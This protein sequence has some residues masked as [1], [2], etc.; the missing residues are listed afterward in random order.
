MNKLY[1]LLLVM[2]P[3]AVMAQE[4][5]VDRNVTVER[6]Y[7]PVIE[8]AG[9]ISSL[10]EI[11]EPV[12]SRQR[13]DYSDIFKPLPLSRYLQSLPM[14]QYEEEKRRRQEAFVRIGLGNHWNTLGEITLPI[15]KKEKDRLDVNFRHLG[16]FGNRK[17]SQ[18]DG[19][20]DYNHLFKTTELVASAGGTHRFFNYFGANFSA[21]GDRL[22]ADS[23]TG[24]IADD[25]HWAYQLQLG[26]RSLPDRDRFRHAG[27][28]S[29]DVLNSPSGWQENVV[30]VR[31][32][33]ST[34]YKR[35][36]YGVDFDL[37]NLTYK[38]PPVLTAAFPDY[39]VLELNPYYLLES[40]NAS[41][42]LGAIA[43][44][45][46]VTGRAFNPA[47]DIQAEW[48]VFPKFLAV[49]GG[50][51]GGFTTV[52]NKRLLE[53][54]PWVKPSLRVKDTYTPLKPYFGLKLKPVY[55]LLLDG[56]VEYNLIKDQ[57]FFVNDS[58]SVGNTPFYSNQFDV[59]YSDASLLRIGGRVN[60][61]YKNLINSSVKIVSNKWDTKTIAQAWMKPGLEADWTLDVKVNPNLTISSNFYYE[62]KRTAKLGT[63]LVD[64][65]PV[66]DLNLSASYRFNRTFSSFVKMN[67]ILNR[68]YEQ[69]FG[70]D[71][72][73]FNFLLGGA[74]SF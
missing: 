57:Y 15:L 28:I 59:E 14:T 55:F 38:A 62:G 19:S 52:T 36:R 66:A 27:H 45:S 30:N 49:Y 33:F 20:I 37:K 68:S 10:P 46:F 54:N 7:Q 24:I 16:T 48:K 70:Y 8:D 61:Q 72:Q 56:F 64:M 35:N 58:V 51:G 47:P 2:F 44:I 73:G 63:L 26:F 43:A 42:R 40:D 31:Y 32:G 74:V 50:V 69:Y 34:L 25:T 65:D 39:S 12:I 13:V 22:K 29:Y 41:L 23:L 67:N 71:V 1:I 18:T 17:F 6:E 21:A 3:A 5:G 11:P 53:E 60:F 9:K 4:S